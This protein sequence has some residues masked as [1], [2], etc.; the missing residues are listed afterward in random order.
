MAADSPK[1][2]ATF[3]TNQLNSNPTATFRDNVTKIIRRHN[4]Q[5]GAYYVDAHKNE[6]PQPGNGVNGLLSHYSMPSLVS[7]GNAFAD[8]LLGNIS[9]F[10]QEGA[11]LKMHEQYKIFEPYFQ[12]DWHATRRLTLNISLRMR[13]F[14]TYSEEN[15]LA[16]N[17]D[18]AA[19]GAGSKQRGSKYR[20]GRVGN[21]YNGWVDCGITPG[22]PDGC[23]K[24]HWTESRA[25]YR[26]R[27]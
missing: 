16:W 23:M 17:F 18:P 7:T 6:I 24:N 4:L 19:Y 8:L 12:D 14:G 25:A 21:P 9:S 27:L 10:T 26:L 11:A 5:F 22:V 15:H 13:F 1:T 20:S 3:P 2:R